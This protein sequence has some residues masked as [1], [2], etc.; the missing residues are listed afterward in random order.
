M[1]VCGAWDLRWVSGVAVDHSATAEWTG[2]W[3]I[4]GAYRAVLG[5]GVP[6]ST[7]WPQSDLEEWHTETP[8]LPPQSGSSLSVWGSRVLTLPLQNEREGAVR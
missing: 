4:R 3:E 6:C 2:G 1:C 5:R 8:T 7:L